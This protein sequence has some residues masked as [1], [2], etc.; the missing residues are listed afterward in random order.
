[1]INGLTTDEINAIGNFNEA[2]KN[3]NNKTILYSALYCPCVHESAW[4][5][6]SV[7][8]TREGANRAIENHK[9]ILTKSLI[10]AFDGY[11]SEEE[12]LLQIEWRDWG[13]EEV[14]LKP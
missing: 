12:A 14:E 5:T 2:M 8:K 4:C 10:E 11:M 1:M 9:N 6:L 7:H 13:V 3:I